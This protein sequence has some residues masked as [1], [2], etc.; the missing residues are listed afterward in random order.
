ML[1][2]VMQELSIVHHEDQGVFHCEL[3]DD[4]L[5]NTSTTRSRITFMI[6]IVKVNAIMDESLVITPL[7]D[8]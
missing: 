6:G 8:S 5:P 7:I 3:L 1:L 2:R 4:E